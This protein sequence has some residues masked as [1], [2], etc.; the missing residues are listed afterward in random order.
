MQKV[1]WPRW[2]SAGLAGAGAILCLGAGAA[3]ALAVNTQLKEEF[4]PFSDC[5]TTTATVCAVAETTSGEF[6]MGNKDVPIAK[7]LELRGG[8]AFN[9][10]SAQP[11]IPARDGD[12]L[13][14]PALT[15]PGGLIGIEGLGGEV[16]ATAELA[17]PVEVNQFYLLEGGGTAVVL[18][19]KIKLDNPLLGGSCWIG[20]DSEP[21]VLNLHDSA[22]G[23]LE[24][25]GKK[26]ITKITGNSLL[27][28]SFA[29][30]AATGC[31]TPSW[32]ITPLVN[33]IVGLPSGSGRNR[34]VMSGSFEQTAVE[35]VLKYDKE[36]KTKK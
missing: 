8:F 28:E 22:K 3:P 26:K 11:L 23:T 10:L 35:W 32:L 5:P 20:S 1:R 18:P 27:D 36:K 17:G 30:P 16:T 13:S 2:R 25:A 4:A 24:L 12:T 31:G 33:L 34:A 29:V 19:L 6:R 21:V 9:S 15:V 14:A 7:P